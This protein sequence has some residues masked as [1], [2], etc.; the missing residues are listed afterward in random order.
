MKKI[1]VLSL[2]AVL[3]GSLLVGCGSSNEKVA[4]QNKE[5]VE[6]EKEERKE[7]EAKEIN[8]AEVDIKGLTESEF[9][10]ATKLGDITTA[11]ESHQKR[12]VD[13]SA[14]MLEN[15]ENSSTG[16]YK[17]GAISE[18]TNYVVDFLNKN[19]ES[20]L[21]NISTEFAVNTTSEDFGSKIIIGFNINSEK[22]LV[23]SDEE[24]KVIRAVL[25]ELEKE[26]IKKHMS[27]IITESENGPDSYSYDYVVPAPQ[28][29][30]MDTV[31]S[32]GPIEDLVINITFWTNYNY[33]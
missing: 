23:I 26:D 24:M 15:F 21:K 25:P 27:D 14:L 3:A 1:L 8:V 2:C 22:G 17:N 11:A 32:E 6:S 12:L 19:E 18:E 30:F 13:G 29:L 31:V 7:V 10:G 4:E 16:G 20:S 28:A 5:Q 9:K 33:V